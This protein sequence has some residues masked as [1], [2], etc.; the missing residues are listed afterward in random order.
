M[1]VKPTWANA[2]WLENNV[3][4]GHGMVFECQRRTKVWELVKAAE[5]CCHV[6]KVF[7]ADVGGMFAAWVVGTT[8]RQA[9]HDG[10]AGAHIFAEELIVA[11]A[12]AVSVPLFTSDPATG[13]WDALVL[14]ERRGRR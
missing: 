8:A 1:R 7:R 9:S 10:L 2:E 11:G 14:F 6:Q 13:D 12:G 5:G 4:A 3:M